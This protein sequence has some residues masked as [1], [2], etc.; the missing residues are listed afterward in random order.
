MFLGVDVSANPANQ[1]EE[2][3]E[4][5]TFQLEYDAARGT[6]S[7]KTTEDKYWAVDAASSG[8]EAKSKEM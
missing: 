4:K 5:E 8:I 3:T 6:W 1:E 2:E 7:I